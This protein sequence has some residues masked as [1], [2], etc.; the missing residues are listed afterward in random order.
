MKIATI[1]FSGSG[2]SYISS[3]L[4]G[5][6]FYWLRSDVIRK[7]L[8]GS[9]YDE[10]TTKKVYEELIKRAKEHKDVILDA[11]FLKKWQRKLVIDNFPN[12]YFFIFVK[13]DENIIRQ[14]LQTRKDISDADFNVYLMQKSSFEPP[15]EI[16]SDRLI[17]IENNNKEQV[18]LFLKS[19]INKIKA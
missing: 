16:P 18:S 5:M 11:T 14:R 12:E 15:D 17:T 19:L 9:F 7:S 3:I 1:G 13:A 2:K 6:G 4:E 8:F 10:E